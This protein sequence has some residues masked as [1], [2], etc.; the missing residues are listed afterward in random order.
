MISW[1]GKMD[2][3][4]KRN[5]GLPD[6]LLLQDETGTAKGSEIACAASF[7]FPRTDSA[8]RSFPIPK[9][10]YLIAKAYSEPL[11]MDLVEQILLQRNFIID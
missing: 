8:R 7:S 10:P 9:S 11:G 4:S 5:K 1:R 2:R 6:G 3:H